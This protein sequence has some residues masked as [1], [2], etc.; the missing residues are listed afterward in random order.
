MSDSAWERASEERCEWT[1]GERRGTGRS[2]VG[3]AFRRR[4]AMV[5]GCDASPIA[6]GRSKVVWKCLLQSGF[7]YQW[8][9]IV[10]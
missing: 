3:R 4:D 9:G 5:E 10:D 2:G 8:I 7:R 6:V 1:E